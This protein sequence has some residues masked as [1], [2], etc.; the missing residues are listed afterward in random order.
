M[1]KDKELLTDGKKLKKKIGWTE[2]DQ[3]SYEYIEQFEWG[4]TEKRLPVKELQ[5]SLD[6]CA[7][8]K[9]LFP[10]DI[11]TLQRFIDMLKKLYY[12]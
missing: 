1:P 10:Y 2:Q 5:D 12:E 11:K 3:S 7:K 9:C 6:F 8:S 4:Y